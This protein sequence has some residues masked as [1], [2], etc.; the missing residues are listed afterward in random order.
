MFL[1]KPIF[2]FM[3]SDKQNLNNYWYRD[4]LPLYEDFDLLAED[5]RLTLDGILTDKEKNTRKARIDYV[6]EWYF[7]KDGLSFNRFIEFMN[8]V[9]NLVQQKS[10]VKKVRLLFLH[11]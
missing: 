5:I 4:I 8:V 3:T 9:K 6:K 1:E 11:C 10:M 7:K 2:G